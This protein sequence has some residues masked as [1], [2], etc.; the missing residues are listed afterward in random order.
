M[1]LWYWIAVALIAFGAV[2]LIESGGA[3]LLAWAFVGAGVLLYFLR[4]R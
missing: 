1:N 3:N 2:G 4:G